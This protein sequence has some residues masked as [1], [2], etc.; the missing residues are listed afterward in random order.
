M[1]EA[2]AIG[3]TLRLNNLI[4]PQLL[5]LAGEFDKLHLNVTTL[6][7]ALAK[8]GTEA[9][10]IRT[11]GPAINSTTAAFGRA[12]KAAS[13]YQSRL[14]AIH[15][16]PPLPPILTPPPIPLPGGG[17]RGPA[18]GGGGGGAPG[19]GGGGR[20]PPA[21]SGGAFHGGNI[22]LGPGGIGMGTVGI[23]AGSAFV[24]L[25]LSA[26]MVYGGHALYE[27]A[28]ALNTEQAR[29]KLFGM[30]DK[31]NNEAY[32]FVE[33]MKVYGTTQTGNMKNF[34]EAQGV[35]R[36]SGLSGPEALE[37]AKL[38]APILAKIEFATEALDEESKAKLRTSGL[39][40]MRWVEMSGGL[41][42]PKKF[43]ELAN[44]GWK[45]TQTSGGAVDW[46]Q[47]RQFS[48]VAG[49][50]GRFLTG[51]GLAALEPIIAELKGGR[52]GTAIRTSLN[53]L[54]GIVKI[55]VPAVHMMM[56]SGLWDASK[57][58]LNKNG[59][60]KKFNGN[61]FTTQD[62][63][64]QSPALWYEKHL[65]PIYEKAMLPQGERARLN[66]MLL[67]NGGALFTLVEN[68]LPTIHR[69]V[70]A[71][72]KALGID[73]SNDIAKKTLSGQ[74]REFEAAW[75][76]FKTVFG[77]AALPAF[78]NLLNNASSFIRGVTEWTQSSGA[79]AFAAAFQNGF[80]WQGKVIDSLFGKDEYSNE[81]HGKG[82]I[83]VSTFG[84]TPGGAATGNPH[85]RTSA[86]Q[87]QIQVSTTINLD[88][89][90]IA[91]AVT[92]HQAK[93]L[94]RPTSNARSFDGSMAPQGNW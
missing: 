46:E 49:N 47:L 60:V 15:R 41:N 29:F 78:S 69:S 7:S 55:P 33:G 84:D 35:F 63:Y 19:G 56:E 58:E 31:L 38:A 92:L 82:R 72:K 10:G 59:G 77:T 13:S 17:G 89:K 42:S 52:A 44:F 53:R 88:S 3:V 87:K 94:S 74:E 14:A 85:I 9:A 21:G 39:S 51:E 1:F 20:K 28:K 25:A 30:G 86:Q 43:N 90:P 50:S 27:S 26:A 54:S 24:P 83:P 23:G 76:D 80:K 32:K 36:E 4:S 18:P 79:T 91:K 62:E 57:V 16:L 5:I 40:M 66:G 65:L 67:G 75:T 70:E 93:E 61:P 8:L 81:G 34:R 71:Q 68:S 22:H 2:Y 11:L 12:S 64:L 37:G 73:E 48:A 6:H 45:M